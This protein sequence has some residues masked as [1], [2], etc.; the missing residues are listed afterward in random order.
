MHF[1]EPLKQDGFEFPADD[2]LP[3]LVDLYFEHVNLY[4]PLLHRPTF[5]KEV[6]SGLHFRNQ[7]FGAVVLAVCA[8]GARYSDD[9]RVIM[10]REQHLEFAGWQW[11]RQAASALPS[12]W[13]TPS[14]NGLQL[15]VVCHSC[16]S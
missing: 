14:L 9:E 15:Y 5:K 7:T 6:V 8:L 12:P 13:K 1:G 16:L 11:L 10:K 4:S 3:S 2:L